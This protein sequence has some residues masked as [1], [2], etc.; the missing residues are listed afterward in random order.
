[1]FPETAPGKRS[2]A[3][4]F[5]QTIYLYLINLF[6]NK[7]ILA[8]WQAFGTSDA[9]DKLVPNIHVIQGRIAT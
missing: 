6:S 9:S 2:V 3:K 1:M 5:I 4:R 7:K 8:C